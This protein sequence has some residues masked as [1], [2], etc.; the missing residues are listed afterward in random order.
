MR[1]F[2]HVWLALT[3]SMCLCGRALA[4]SRNASALIS[5]VDT[6]IY[7]L[8]QTT[9]LLHKKLDLLRFLV[10]ENDSLSQARWKPLDQ[11]ATTAEH[12]LDL[13]SHE[14]T[15][16]IQHIKLITLRQNSHLQ[17]QRSKRRKHQSTDFLH[18]LALIDSKGILSLVNP[19]TLVALWQ[20]Q[21]HVHN[22]ADIKYLSGNRNVI[23]VIDRNGAI[24]VYSLRVYENHRLIIGEF[25][26]RRA[27]DQSVCLKGLAPSLETILASHVHNIFS[28]TSQ[29]LTS[30]SSTFGLHME[31]E[32][33]YVTPRL[34]KPNVVLTQTH[35][36]M[37][38]VAATQD[39]KIFVFGKSGVCIRQLNIPSPAK[40]MIAINGGS[41]TFAMDNTIGLL[42]VYGDGLPMYCV[43]TKHDIISLTRDAQRSNL[44]YA[45]T[46]SGSVLLIHLHLSSSS[47]IFPPTCHII[48]ELHSIQ[49]NS[50]PHLISWKHHVFFISENYFVGYTL[51]DNHLAPQFLFKK[52]LPYLSS[53]CGDFDLDITREAPDAALAVIKLP[54]CNGGFHVKIFQCLLTQQESLMILCAGAF[55][56]WYRSKNKKDNPGQFDEEEIIRLAQR[57]EA[58]RQC[59]GHNTN[60]RMSGLSAQSL[61]GVKVYNLSAGKTLPQWLAQK[62]KK[63]LSRDEEY[64]RRLE[65]VQ[66]FTFPIASHCVTMSPDGNYIIATGTYPPIVKVYDVRDL[67][68]KFERR[69]DS[70]V[71]KL[72]CLSED[73][74][75]LAF[76]Q[77]DRSIALHAP[78][79]THTD[80]RI[81]KFGR[82]MVYHRGNCD[83]YVGASDSEIY[84]VNL[85]QGQFLAGLQ[86]DMNAVNVVKINPVHQLLGAG[87]EN[88][89]VEMWD[90]RNQTR[91]G[92]LNVA[93]DVP[94][95]AL[96]FD[97]DG[98]TFAIGTH[99]GEVRLYDLRS[100]TPLLTKKHQYQLPIVDLTFHEGPS[101]QILSSDAKCIKIWDK[102]N[103]KLFTNLETSADINDVCVV[104]G[105]AGHSGVLMVAGEQERVMSYYIPELGIAPKWCSFLDNLT[106][107]LEEEA[108]TTVYDDY[109]FVT[110]AELA[111]LGLNHMIGTPLLKAYMHGF[112]MDA[113]LYAKVNAVAAP[114]AY[115]TWR[116]EKV[117]QKVKEKQANRITIQRRLPKVNRALAEQLVS[118]KKSKKS[119]QEA[120]E[121]QEEPDFDNPLGDDRFAKM[122]TSTDFEVD[123][124]SETYRAMHPNAHFTKRKKEEDM[125]SDD[126]GDD[127]EEGRFDLVSDE[128]REGRPSDASS[129]EDESEEEEEVKPKETAPTKKLPKFYELSKGASIRN[130]VGLGSAADAEAQKER[131]KLNKLPLAERIKMEKVKQQERSSMKNVQGAGMVREMT[132]MPHHGRAPSASQ[133]NERQKRG[134]KELGLKGPAKRFRR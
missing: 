4:D 71:Q 26:K 41:L 89:V 98:L 103:G 79:G 3:T 64:R 73:F 34:N 132:Y 124:E 110:R 114:M 68:M 95:S 116:K 23:A 21:I 1:M 94:I 37:H 15:E 16:N 127:E 62:T 13:A 19:T 8:E 130:V 96:S 27:T 122:F 51:Y 60:G 67:S 24:F 45:G 133:R 42:N 86:T 9:A 57:F 65:L 81:P 28:P 92:S 20:V 29:I 36:D 18:L 33:L 6:E 55:I 129:T 48:H 131:R 90:T 108:S 2:S 106:E 80:V 105:G 78:Y 25:L 72:V 123:E 61:N 66:D 47:Q 17:Q 69:L 5:I 100:S 112:F 117:Q 121:A 53:N 56:I 115:D 88:G 59:F 63:A 120:Q 113:R 99:T 54:Q 119:A 101:K 83:M 87:G 44:I 74:G 12:F 46:S 82:D 93:Q 134:I 111:N 49:A 30:S 128:E 31:F 70:Q 50:T 40:A 76:L 58:V 38:L 43:A 35:H 102:T 104:R 14:F 126:D 39:A 11:E 22:V 118:G 32:L 10:Y 85:D 77:M 107:E 109:K 97:T 125:D 75:K 84:R 91:V 7:A 52:F